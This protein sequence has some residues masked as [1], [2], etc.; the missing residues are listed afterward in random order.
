MSTGAAAMRLTFRKRAKITAGLLL[1]RG[2]NYSGLKI[3][4]AKGGV[5]D[6]TEQPIFYWEKS[7]AISGMAFYNA[8]QF[9]Q[10]QHKLFI[11]A[12]K[13]KKCHRD[14]R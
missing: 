6:G 11:G 10:W 8:A 9:P 3:P 13:E 5:V 7:P 4:E 14:E 12:L 1:P 2:I